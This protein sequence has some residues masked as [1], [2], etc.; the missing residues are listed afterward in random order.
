ML[1]PSIDADGVAPGRRRVGQPVRGVIGGAALDLAEHPLVPGE[2]VEAGVPP[3]RDQ[4]LLAG[5]LVL[6][7]PGPAAAVLVD[8][9]VSDRFRVARQAR[10]RFLRERGVHGRP[11]D[12][13]VP[14]PPRP[15]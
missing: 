7:P 9:Q 3:V 11:R 13:V 5:F 4:D 2:V 12:A 6:P 10:F 8:A 15:G 14:G 1:I